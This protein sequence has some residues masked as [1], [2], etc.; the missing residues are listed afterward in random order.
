VLGLGL[1]A[2]VSREVVLRIGSDGYLV[3]TKRRNSVPGAPS[4]SNQAID[5]I[6]GGSL[7]AC[8][9]SRAVR[10]RLAPDGARGATTDVPTDRIFLHRQQVIAISDAFVREGLRVSQGGQHG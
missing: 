10:V 4:C 8:D 7:A 3:P 1:G 2:S 9:R 5:G 6:V